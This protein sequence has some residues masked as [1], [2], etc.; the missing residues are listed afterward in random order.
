[1]PASTTCPARGFVAQTRRPAA[2]GRR[3]AGRRTTAGTS[4][5]AGSCD[6][7]G[8]GRVSVLRAEH[9]CACA[10]L[11]HTPRSVPRNKARRLQ[12]SR[13]RAHE[14]AAPERRR[15]AQSRRG[16]RASRKQL[17]YR[18]AAHPAVPLQASCSVPVSLQVLRFSRN[19][20]N[21]PRSFQNLVSDLAHC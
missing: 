16:L 1:L 18:P 2:D 3:G 20:S 21:S 13:A 19:L 10:A 15:L 6:R 17:R 8:H 4:M 7:V 11:R 9:Q 5:R 12:D 14:G